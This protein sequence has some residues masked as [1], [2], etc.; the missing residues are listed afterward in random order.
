MVEE[1]KIAAAA[2]R[3]VELGKELETAGHAALDA[4]TVVRARAVLH[5]WI[6]GMQGIV[7]NPALGRVTVIDKDGNASS[8]ASASLAFTLSAA[9]ITRAT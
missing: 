7:V 9:G 8:I 3:I 6:E 1:A 4:P 5:E 2:D